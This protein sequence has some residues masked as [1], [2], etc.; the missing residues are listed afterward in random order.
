MEIPYNII[1]EIGHG[2]HGKVYLAEGTNGRVALKVCRKPEDSN[3]CENWE[4]EL[5]GWLLL[6]NMPPH[7]GIVRIYDVGYS[8]SENVFWVAMELADSEDGHSIENGATYRP[9]TLASLVSAELALPISQCLNIAEDLAL[10]LVHLQRNHLLHRDI[11]PGNILI[12]KGKPVLADAGLV[13]DVREVA[14][15]V[16]T[17]GYVPPE[18]HTT[19]QGDIYSLGCTLWKI[20]TGRSP[21]EAGM[22]PYVEADTADPDFG[23]FLS[24]V[25]KAMSRVPSRRYRSAKALHKALKS[26]IASRS[27]RRIRK[28]LFCIFGSI[29]IVTLFIVVLIWSRGFNHESGGGGLSSEDNQK[30]SPK[31]E[32]AEVS[33]SLPNL[34]IGIKDLKMVERSKKD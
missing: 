5:R 29:A 1:C 24:I 16:G 26:L 6:K 32:S 34:Q 22:A 9:K 31:A 28:L 2:A 23:A 7:P 19:I 15:L 25:D 3:R 14:S 27:R 8:H 17:A 12:C 20:C 21:E 13:V 18:N 33:P 4:R 11:K 30:A 10:A